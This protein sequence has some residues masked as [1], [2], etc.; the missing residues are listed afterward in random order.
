MIV[1]DMSKSYIFSAIVK[2]GELALV[3]FLSFVFLYLFEPSLFVRL[4]SGDV[5]KLFISASIFISLY[6]FVENFFRFYQFCFK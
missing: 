2:L 4:V 3:T 1:F 5:V 6:F